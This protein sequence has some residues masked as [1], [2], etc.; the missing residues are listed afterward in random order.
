LFE[1][2]FGNESDDFAGDGHYAVAGGFALDEFEDAM[3]RRLFEIGKVH[4]N[5]GHAAHEESCAFDEAHAAGGEADGFGDLLRYINVAGIE[6][7]VV[8][9]EEFAG[10]DDSGTG[11][12]VDARFAEVGT[13][14]GI[15]C[16]LGANAFELAA[17]DVLEVLAIGRCGRC[18]VEVDGNLEALPDF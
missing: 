5:L 17:T 9:D 11:G 1:R 12:G 2:G 15:G 18:F 8:G 10:A 14:S 7:D 16:D 6:E 4:G 3:D 13:S